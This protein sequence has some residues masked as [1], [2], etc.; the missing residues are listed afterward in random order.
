MRDSSDG[1]RL[2]RI[3]A[4]VTHARPISSE[5]SSR[6]DDTSALRVAVRATSRAT[7]LR[8]LQQTESTRRSLEQAVGRPTALASSL[9]HRGDRPVRVRL[10]SPNRTRT[11]RRMLSELTR[12]L[13]PFCT[14]GCRKFGLPCNPA[15][16]GRTV[17]VDRPAS[18]SPSPLALSP[19]RRL[20]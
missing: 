9:S 1:R 14:C 16:S 17:R 19:L 3:S 20:R 8:R 10:A 7:E 6:T 12:I 2:P 11:W 18:H 13:Y 5:P 4:L 15:Y